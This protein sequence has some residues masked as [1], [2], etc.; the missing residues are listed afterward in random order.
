[1]LFE[2]MMRGDSDSKVVII[3][4]LSN[5]RPSTIVENLPILVSLSE[6]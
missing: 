5:R 1:M 2:E 3:A 6:P 4:R